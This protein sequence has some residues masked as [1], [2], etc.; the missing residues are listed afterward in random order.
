MNL[1]IHPC[2]P[3]NFG[4]ILILDL[5]NCKKIQHHDRLQNYIVFKCFKYFHANKK[6]GEICIQILI[7]WTCKIKMVF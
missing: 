2:K 7:N 3:Y 1:T 4:S 5:I 6:Y